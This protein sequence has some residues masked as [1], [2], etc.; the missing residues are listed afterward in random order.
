MGSESYFYERTAITGETETDM[1]DLMLQNRAIS[2]SGSLTDNDII[3]DII[4]FIVAGHETV[5]NILCWAMLELARK[6][7]I[8]DKCCSE[9]ME[10][11]SSG[12]TINYDTANK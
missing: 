8:Q 5:T 10:I 7:D 3:D 1:L 11:L 9:V 4:L 2:Q 12:E 6:P